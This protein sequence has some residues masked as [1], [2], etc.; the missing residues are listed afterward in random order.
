[1]HWLLFCNQFVCF[2]SYDGEF[3][4][5]RSTMELQIP[6][7]FFKR[8]VLKAFETISKSQDRRFQSKARRYWKFKIVLIVFLM[9]DIWELQHKNYSLMMYI[10][11][12]IY[13]YIHLFI[14][15]YLCI[16]TYILYIY[17][18]IC[19]YTYIYYIYIY[20]YIYI[21]W[22]AVYD[23]AAGYANGW[24]TGNKPSFFVL[25]YIQLQDA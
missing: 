24:V 1:M 22:S 6:H 10:Y 9:F 3:S 12:Y 11:T 5:L 14:Y 21:F 16:Y 17:I 4:T 23:Y 15:I 20:I 13:I 2:T 18:Y 7:G 19:I 25:S 8:S